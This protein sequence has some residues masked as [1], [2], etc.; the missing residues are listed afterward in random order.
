MSGFSADWLALREP[1]DHRARDRVLLR[2]LEGLFAGRPLV[3]VV[4]LGCG[5]GSNLRA[6]AAYL[7][8]RQEW[9]L[10]DHD[11]ALLEAAR[12]Q[13]AGW[14]DRSEI[15]DGRQLIQG[16]GRDIAVSF[17]D[18]DL[19]HDVDAAIPVGTELVTAAALFDLVSA[20]WIDD[21]ADAVTARQ[22]V[23]YTAL[24][25]DGVMV[26]GG[27]HGSHPADAMMVAAFHADQRRDKGFGPAAGPEASRMLKHA[28]AVRGYEV[29]TA[30]S[31]WRLGSADAE[32]AREVARG[33]AAVATASGVDP[34]QAARWL[35]A[36]AAEVTWTI[37]HT[38]LIAVPP[39]R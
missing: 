17:A 8:E 32:L 21:V 15:R 3:R 9:R 18:L 11:P 19:A 7:P 34:D 12:Q 38:D 13:L 28:F 23:F 37:G 24:T 29:G 35:E 1:A 36:R 2:R 33:V 6:C 22:A 27:P 5:T 25:F 31:P 26:P 16:Q 30:S 20:A 14:A 10:V 39:A 4:D